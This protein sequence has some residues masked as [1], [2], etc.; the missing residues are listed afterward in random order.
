LFERFTEHA[1]RSIFF[2]R[3]EASM[4]GTREI[5]CEGLLLGILRED[6]TVAM[7][8]GIGALDSIRSELEQLAPQPRE[9]RASTSVEI[10]LSEESKRV[11]KFAEEEADNLGHRHIDSP[12]LMLGVL[13][14]EDSVA[15]HLLRKRGI[16][17]EQFR[18]VVARGERVETAPGPPAPIA[19][20]AA[21]LQPTISGLERLVDNTSPL[22]EFADSY[23][24]QRLKRK[25]WTRKEALGH[26]IEWAMV[27]HQWLTWVLMES[28]VR[29]AGYPDEAAVAVQHYS[30]FP[31]AETVD[32]WVSLNKLLIHTLLRIPSRK[33]TVSCRIG[34][35]EPVSLAK[36]ID[37]YLEYCEEIVG[38]ILARL[39]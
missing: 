14:I 4:L 36:L 34:I 21:W 12:H 26:L 32:L 9:G 25:P 22:R 35:G 2:A 28:K 19:P 33:L 1:R 30:D 18:Q 5:T 37:T 3:Y 24:D 16:E 31:W 29:A 7:R 23:G 20:Q 8:V 17:Y 6:K 10:P 27:H 13:R 38:Q 15:A 11:L 39:D